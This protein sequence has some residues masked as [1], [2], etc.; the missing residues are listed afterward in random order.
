MVLCWRYATFPILENYGKCVLQ[1]TRSSMH[2]MHVNDH[3]LTMVIQYTYH[4]TYMKP[5]M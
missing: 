4:E 1:N 2:A 5:C 3:N